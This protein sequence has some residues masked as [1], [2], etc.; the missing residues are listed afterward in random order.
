[1]SNWKLGYPSGL[2]SAASEAAGMALYDKFSVLPITLDTTPMCRGVGQVNGTPLND[3]GGV[4][5]CDHIHVYPST[6]DA[7]FPGNTSFATDEFNKGFVIFLSG[8]AGGYPAQNENK[9]FKVDDTSASTLTCSGDNLYAAGVRDGDYF[10]VVTGSPTYSFPSGRNPI[11]RDF[12]KMV[13]VGPSQRMMM[14]NKGLLF[15]LGYVADD[16]V[17]IAYLTSSKDAN[18]LETMLS[19]TVNYMG[20]DYPYASSLG[21]TDLGG[22]PMIL[23]TGSNDVRNQFMVAVSD[24]KIIKSAVRSDDF[25]EVMVH[26]MGY[27]KSTHRGI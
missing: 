16:F 19:H 3:T 23:E 24:W 9:A 21:D 2:E 26:F 11:R 27:W 7:A 4:L 12:K 13:N 18:R 1:M 20:F 6:D 25:Y 22:A 17:I 8:T 10:E 5:T 14:Y 15:P